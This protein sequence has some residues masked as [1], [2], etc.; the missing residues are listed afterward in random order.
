MRKL[1]LISTIV[2]LTAPLFAQQAA[3]PAPRQGAQAPG[4]LGQTTNRPPPPTGPAPRLPD[5][6]PDLS[7]LWVGGGGPYMERGGGIKRD[8]IPVL[9]WVKQYMAKLDLAADPMAFCL[10]MGVVRKM[11]Y[12]WR[13]VQDQMSAKATRL[14]IL[15]EGNIHTYRQI[16][17]DGRKHPD[18]DMPTW[19]GHSV[20][21]WEKD[22]LVVETT[23][24]NGRAWLDRAG[25]P[26][27]EQSKIT[28]RYTRLNMGTLERI[29][30]VD[31]PGAYSK[32]FT[33]KYTAR[34]SNPEDEI[35]EYFCTENNQYGAAGGFKAPPEFPVIAPP[36][37]R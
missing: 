10:P 14:Y 2:A 36:P 8:E 3:S 21:H 28:E 26:Q 27:T 15:E 25:F 32:P 18:D 12:P 31:D 37:S 6:T 4:A 5:G 33:L 13:F 7:G 30:T 11:P 23:N 22:T 17:V 19:M 9:P 16:F 35:H 34:L 24:F 1:L 29:V 20:G